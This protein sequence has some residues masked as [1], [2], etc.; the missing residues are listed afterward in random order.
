MKIYGPYTRKDGRKHIVIVSN[1][2]KQTK[3]YPR[4]LLEQR[5]G[6]ELLDTETVDHIDGDFTNDA[7]SNLQILSRADN[8]RKSVVYAES[9]IL[10]CKTC[11]QRFT[12]RKV[13]EAERIKRNNDGPFCSK[14]CVGKYHN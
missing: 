2:K 5:L 4:Y 8:A 1:G 14:T 13:V 6:R 12:R 7:L 10:I 11:Q 3:S 9:I